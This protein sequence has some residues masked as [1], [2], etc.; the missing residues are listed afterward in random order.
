MNNFIV[1]TD[2]ASFDGGIN[3]LGTGKVGSWRG[4]ICLVELAGNKANEYLPKFGGGS[5]SAII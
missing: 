4:F 1:K 2:E 5:P 3:G